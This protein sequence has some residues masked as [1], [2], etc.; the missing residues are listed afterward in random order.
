METLEERQF[1]QYHRELILKIKGEA[2]S[3]GD[4]QKLMNIAIH[5]GAC[6]WEIVEKVSGL[7]ERIVT[8]HSS[9]FQTHG[10]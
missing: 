10:V 5:Y 8:K 2:E 9:L 6:D 7:G 1:R 3:R 4:W